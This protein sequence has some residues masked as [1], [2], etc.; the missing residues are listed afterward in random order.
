MNRIQI[1]AACSCHQ[2]TKLDSG[3][4]ICAACGGAEF[5]AVNEK[6][7]PRCLFCQFTVPGKECHG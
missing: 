4:V 5:R 1:C 7:G 3:A 6:A 2:T